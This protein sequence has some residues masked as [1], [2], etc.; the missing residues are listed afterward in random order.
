MFTDPTIVATL[1]AHVLFWPSPLP[2][3]L[4]I[5]TF[6]AARSLLTADAVQY[7]GERYKCM[8]NPLIFHNVSVASLLVLQVDIWNFAAP[9]YVP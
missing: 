6:A 1:N 9:Q 8:R 5:D 7:F 4:P 3:Q 2:I